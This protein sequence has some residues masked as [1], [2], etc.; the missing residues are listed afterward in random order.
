MVICHGTCPLGCQGML[1]PKRSHLSN[2]P[3]SLSREPEGWP[4]AVPI[5]GSCG[6]TC[7]Q[8]SVLVVFTFSSE[9]FWLVA[10]EDL[11][12]FASHENPC[13]WTDFSLKYTCFIIFYEWRWSI[14]IFASTGHT[15]WLWAP[16]MLFT[17][18]EPLVTKSD[19]AS[20]R[21]YPVKWCMSVIYIFC[22]CLH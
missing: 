4:R 21:L 7:S 12:L 5:S 13:L 18:R 10:F 2:F 22:K 8:T 15:K 9:S 3:P 14:W 11:K 19:G 6:L 1:P 16:P 20:L 17:Q